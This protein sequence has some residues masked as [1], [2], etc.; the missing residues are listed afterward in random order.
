MEDAESKQVEPEVAAKAGEVATGSN[1]YSYSHTIFGPGG[2]ILDPGLLEQLQNTPPLSVV[3]A[4]KWA[5]FFDAFSTNR[6][7]SDRLTLFALTSIVTDRPLQQ[8]IQ[9][10]A[11]QGVVEWADDKWDHECDEGHNDSFPPRCAS[12]FALR[13]SSSLALVIE[14]HLGDI[15]RE[16]SYYAIGVGPDPATLPF[17]GEGEIAR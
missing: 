2:E 13:L 17:P 16:I 9:E 10:N 11:L 5:T 6:Y 8:A 1:G 12:L 14:S 15:D 7:L 4:A 3:D